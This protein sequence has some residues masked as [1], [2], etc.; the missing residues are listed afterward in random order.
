MTAEANRALGDMILNGA[1]EPQEEVETA[2]VR[3]SPARARLIERY[4]T[5][6]QKAELAEHRSNRG[7]GTKTGPNQNRHMGG[8]RREFRPEDLF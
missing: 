8:L 3:M 4:G 1:P 7:T 2:P 6:E 5:P